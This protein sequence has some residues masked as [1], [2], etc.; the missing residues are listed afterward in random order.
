MNAFIRYIFGLYLVNCADVEI[1]QIVCRR[2]VSRAR[3]AR[4]VD[5]QCFVSVGFFVF[6]FRMR[7]LYKLLCLR[8]V[9]FVTPVISQWSR[10]GS[11]RVSIIARIYEEFFYCDKF[12]NGDMFYLSHFGC[13]CLCFSCCVNLLPD[14]IWRFVALFILMYFKSTFSI[15]R[16]QYIL[17]L[18]SIINV[19]KKILRIKDYFYNWIVSFRS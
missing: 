10:L 15:T 7:A 6:F 5:R 2:N 12:F 3:A 1:P 17:F 19:L 13:L 18:I 14:Y 11:V 4:A 8:N 9:F 16:L